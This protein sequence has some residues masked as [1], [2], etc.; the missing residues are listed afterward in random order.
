V[1]ARTVMIAKIAMGKTED[2]PDS[3]AFSHGATINSE[4]P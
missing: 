2:A 3:A 1:K 4:R